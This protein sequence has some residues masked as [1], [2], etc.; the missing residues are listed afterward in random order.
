MLEPAATA[1]GLEPREI[2]ATMRSAHR[3]TRAADVPDDPVVAQGVRSLS[4]L[5]R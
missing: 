1:A 5:G 4:G 2:T 3:T